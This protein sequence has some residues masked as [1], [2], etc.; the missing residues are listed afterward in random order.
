[1][2][3]NDNIPA[4][5]KHSPLGIIPKDW[6]VKE[7]GQLAIQLKKKYAP[8]PYEHKRCIELENMTKEDGIL[9]GWTDSSIEKST[10]TIFK[11]GN[12]LFGKLRPYLR[13]YWQAS[14]DGICSSE[15]WV[16]KNRSTCN[17]NYL[18]WLIQS[19][20]F[21]QAASISSGSKMPRSDWNYVSSSRIVLPP[22]PEQ[23]KI[24]GILSVWD[25]A[26][27]KQS[28]LVEKL[29]TRKRGLMQQLLTGKKRLN[30]F[31]GEWGK[32]AYSN[33]LK[34]VVRKL[35]WSED[36]LYQLI[37]VRRRSGGL[38]QRESLYGRDIQTKNLRPALTGDFLISK[39]QIVHGASGL[40]TKEFNNMKISGSYIALIEKDSNILNI[41]YFNLW[42]QMPYFYYQTLISSYGV[43]I[44]KMTF[45]LETFLSLEIWL[46]Q[47]KEQHAIVEIMKSA[48]E[49]ICLAKQKLESLRQQKKGLMQVLLTGKKRVIIE[50]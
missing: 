36:E 48:N 18:F 29:E 49:E 25:S 5:Y 38:F 33:I 4:G 39:M 34:E 42:S 11:S 28:A 19:N 3:Q 23:Q 40:T 12:I 32:Y 16:L 13:K 41:E 46:P 43:H 2:K 20:R 22:L 30:G 6:E 15:I 47:I 26:I 45:D 10:K 27:E 17:S 31:S 1:M 14:F 37:S 9:I 8:T 7:I 44:E 35:T 21:I 50:S 24:V